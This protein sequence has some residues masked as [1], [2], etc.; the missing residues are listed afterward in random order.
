LVIPHGGFLETEL[1]L[2][3]SNAVGAFST[4]SKDNVEL[5]AEAV[6]VSLPTDLVSFVKPLLH[7]SLSKNELPYSEISPSSE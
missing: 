5:V 2:V 3:K 7:D 6:S 4:S 1:L